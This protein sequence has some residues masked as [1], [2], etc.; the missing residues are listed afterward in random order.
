METNFFWRGDGFQFLNRLTILSHLMV[1]H[2]VKIWVSGSKPKSKYWIDDIKDIQIKN[3]DKVVNIKNFLKLPKANV[4]TASALWRFTYLYKYGGLYCDTDMVALKTFPN[5]KW[6]I[7]SY[8]NNVIAI[9]IIKAPKNHPVFTD[10][11]D[12]IRPKWG[13]V[14]IFTGYCLRHNLKK[15]HPNNYFYPKN[16]LNRGEGLL[17]NSK[18]PN[19]YGLHF[20]FKGASKININHNT[21]NKYPNSILARL[22]R[23]IFKNYSLIRGK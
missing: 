7:A 15:T 11:I 18:I 22:Q 1:G 10:C 9:G 14:R 20:Y 12:N 6:I 8:D 17:K 2:K 19:S 21:I 23:K 4:R 13:N 5:D 16:I 3:A